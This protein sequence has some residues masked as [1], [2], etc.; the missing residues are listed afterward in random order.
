M[1]LA[2]IARIMG[3][4]DHWRLGHR[5]ALDGVRGLAI[6]LVLVCHSQIKPLE[7]AGIVGVT[8]FFAL[9]GFLITRLLVE[10]YDRRG[11]Q[12]SL[13]GFYWRRALR[14][15][16]AL[17]VM[18]LLTG[19][20]W[21]VAGRETPFLPVIA[22]VGN[23]S[24][25]AGNWLGPW[26]HTWTLAVEEQFYLVWPVAL[27]LS[28]RA[29]GRRGALTV[30]A[31]GAAWSIVGRGAIFYATGNAARANFGTDM[32]IDALL[33]GAA[34]AL[35][36]VGRRR[37][38]PDAWLAASLCALSLTGAG[39]ARFVILPTV[40]AALSVALVY[41]AATSPRAWLSTPWLC[42]LGR[43]SYGIYLWHYPALLISQAIHPGVF[44]AL[45]ALAAGVVVAEASWRAVERP[46]LGLKSW[47]RRPR[48]RSAVASSR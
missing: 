48:T 16:P 12:V 28:L 23:W 18:M 13:T 31:V 29:W 24:M 21:A 7:S 32:H 34:L 38:L 1:Y 14:L 44:S 19:A 40:V 30:C 9:S 43:R 17:A 45:V 26:T 15:F 42:Y 39:A 11:G 4:M 36:V 5:P 35:V 22:Y 27:I 3:C 10:E 41:C 25:A 46:A 20:I 47:V 2:A 8:L 37:A 33:G 6:L